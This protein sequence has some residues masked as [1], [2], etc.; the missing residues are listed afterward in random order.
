MYIHALSLLLFAAT[1]LCTPTPTAAPDQDLDKRQN[2][3][4]QLLTLA[5]LAGIT[6]L[7]TNTAVLI[8][9]GPV[10]QELA[11]ALPTS[12]VLS[13]LETA[14][15]REFLSN[16]VHDPSYASSFESAFAAGSSPSWF[17]SLPT[18]VRSYL[19][20]YTG[21]AGIA[22]AAAELNNVTRNAAAMATGSMSGMTSTSSSTGM[23]STESSSATAAGASTATSK[24]SSG[25]AARQAGAIA[26]GIVGAVG[27]LG[28]AAVL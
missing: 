20:T 4:P 24:L 21:F 11:A 27:I 6:A 12:S 13:V 7:P 14:A 28:V 23:S 5:S 10:A 18:D 16:I 3:I 8:A 9:L 15:P 17:K 26:A 19:H 2:N 22:T 25:G 1:S